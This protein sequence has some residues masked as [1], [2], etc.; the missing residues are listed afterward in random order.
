ML[1]Y[2]SFVYIYGE[3][4]I[5]FIKFKKIILYCFYL[6]YLFLAYYVNEICIGKEKSL[7]DVYYLTCHTI[8]HETCI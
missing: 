2:Y 3:F 6:I 8:Y 5:I 1:C 7:L 4:I